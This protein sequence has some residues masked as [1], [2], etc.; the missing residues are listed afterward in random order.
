MMSD[1][2]Q[3]INYNLNSNLFTP[4]SM[5]TNY[6]TR[7]KKKKENNIINPSNTNLV[8]EQSRDLSPSIFTTTASINIRCLNAIKLQLLLDLMDKD[9]IQILGLAETKLT[10][11]EIRFLLDKNSSYCIFGHNDNINKNSK[12][13]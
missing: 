2:N 4:T 13:V 3:L 6:K 12:G 10:E 5:I 7:K 1:N 9:K 11:K 8:N